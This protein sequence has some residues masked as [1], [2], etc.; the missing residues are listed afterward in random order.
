MNS[1]NALDPETL[2]KMAAH[3]NPKL[4]CDDPAKA[5]QSARDLLTAAD[6]ELAKQAA[7]QA[8]ETELY[9]ESQRR[10][11]LFPHVERISVAEAFERLPGHYKT[12]TRFAAAL[13]KENLIIVENVVEDVDLPQFIKAWPDEEEKFV[14]RPEVT[15]LRAVEEL[16]KRKR[17]QKKAQDRARKKDAKQKKQKS[18]AELKAGEAERISRKAEPE[19][20]Q[21]KPQ[22]KNR[23]SQKARQVS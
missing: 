10:D 22:S 20:K 4:A 9:K 6:P 11:E 2:A 3:L 15:S 7:E 18:S 19:N 23:K 8:E 12:E 16:F 13:R 1:P 17:E 5:I 21:R 14:K